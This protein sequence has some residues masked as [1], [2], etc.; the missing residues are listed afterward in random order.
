MKH[1]RVKTLKEAMDL[2]IKLE[3]EGY[4]ATWNCKWDHYV[5]MYA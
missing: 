2:V 1:I 3:L 4:E 5:V